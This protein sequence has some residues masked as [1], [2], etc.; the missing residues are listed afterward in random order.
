[1]SRHI[2]LAHIR[3]MCLDKSQCVPQQISCAD[4]CAQ[5]LVEIRQHDA[6]SKGREGQWS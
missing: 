1:M 4:T 5:L 3:L 2:V 6:T